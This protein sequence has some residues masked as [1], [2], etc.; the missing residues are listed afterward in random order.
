[1]EQYLNTKII[2]NAGDVEYW[3]RQFDNTS[4]RNMV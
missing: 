3:Q 2:Q 4:E 1:L